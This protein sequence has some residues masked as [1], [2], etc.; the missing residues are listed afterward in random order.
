MR[1]N[2][3]RCLAMP[4]NALHWE[5]LPGL[6]SARN[7]KSSLLSRNGKW[8]VWKMR[9]MENVECGKWGVWKKRSMENKE[10]GKCVVKKMRSMENGKYW[11]CGVWKMK[12][13]ENEKCGKCGVCMMRCVENKECRRGSRSLKWGLNFCNNVL[14]PINI[15]GI[16]K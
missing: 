7:D 16:Q 4:C 1:C 11:K 13:I 10:C 3:L 9:S 2:A 15:W 5:M 14:E 8:G 6:S 12:S